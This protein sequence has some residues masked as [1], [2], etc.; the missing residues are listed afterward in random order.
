MNQI[1]VCPQ[2]GVIVEHMSEAIADHGG[3]ALIV[4]Y[5]EDG[6]RRHTLRV[7]W[8]GLRCDVQY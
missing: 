2:G 6:S 3:C 1:E 5:G 7:S 4:D 8:R